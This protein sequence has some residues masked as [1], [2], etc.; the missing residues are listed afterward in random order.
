MIQ[1]RG[2]WVVGM[3]DGTEGYLNNNPEK[4]NVVPCRALG[5]VT[6]YS[7]NSFTFTCFHIETDFQFLI[8]SR[9]YM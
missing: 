4:L 7:T 1:R 9:T 5:E 3:I 8:T 6:S 2:S